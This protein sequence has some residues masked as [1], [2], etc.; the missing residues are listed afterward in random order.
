ML[1]ECVETKCHLTE[2]VFSTTGRSKHSPVC[3]V[4]TQF[5]FLVLLMPL[6]SC[7]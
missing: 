5:Q 2:I 3:N 6:K 1:A 7:N 4:G